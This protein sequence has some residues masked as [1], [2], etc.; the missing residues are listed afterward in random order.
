MNTLVFA[1][2]NQHKISEIAHV[3]ENSFN[4]K[5]LYDIG[6]YEDII[7]DGITL[8]ENAKIKAN[9]VFNN[10]R[11]PCFAD[12]SGLEVESLNG[13]PG[14]FSARYAGLQKNNE[15]NINKLLQK[16]AHNKNRNACFRTVICLKTLE[17]EIYFEGICEGIICKEKRG[18]NGFGYDP[19]FVPNGF[20]KTFAELPSEIKNK[21]SHRGVAF[22]KLIAYLNSKKS[23]FDL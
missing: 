4:L 17:E 14:V 11:I 16:L 15:D 12:D 23:K 18:E 22:K 3:L 20:N 9:H 2:H 10:Y 19:I 7:E 21:I 13:A 6:C 5:S 1:T 8:H